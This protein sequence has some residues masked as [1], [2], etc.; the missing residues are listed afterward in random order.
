MLVGSAEKA[1]IGPQS[2]RRNA[3]ALIFG[4]V[5]NL[6]L[7]Y[8]S[9]VD[10]RGMAFHTSGGLW[11]SVGRTPMA[12]VE[13]ST[14]GVLIGAVGAL[15]SVSLPIRRRPSTASGRWGESEGA[16]PNAIFSI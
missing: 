5:V 14:I 7:K 6:R 10:S 1:N 15:S 13:P 16:R 11:F 9:L 3:E 12:G 4:F 2:R 8:R